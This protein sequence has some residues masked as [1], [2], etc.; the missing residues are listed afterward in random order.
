MNARF[1]KG[2]IFAAAL[3][4]GLLVLWGVQRAVQKPPPPTQ[5]SQIAAP[6]PASAPSDS[7]ALPAAQVIT[8]K[9]PTGCDLDPVAQANGSRDGQ[10]TLR[11]GLAHGSA[12]EPTAYVTV[13]RE[14]AADGR[15]RDAEIAL[16][17]A[18]QLA[19]EATPAP[20]TPLAD[21]QMKLAEH[22]AALGATDRAGESR[23]EFLRRAQV[24]FAA[25]EQSYEHVLGRQASKTRM[26]ARKLASLND[27]ASLMASTP[28]DTGS[29][30]AARERVAS[31]EELS[32]IDSDIRRLQAQASAL[33]RDPEG[34]RRRTEYA[35][36][37]QARCTDR[38][39]LQR[40]YQQR[41]AQLLQE[42]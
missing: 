42:F 35:D 22:Y 8:A 17:T 38:E 32:Q 5:A 31:D 40:W 39:C 3:A 6:K 1:R 27:P 37:R 2:L 4:A 15:L 20:S 7:S 28:P 24:L 12:P 30:G 36:S 9:H 18:C 16:I 41:R 14:A 10:F 19:G 25:S 23:S 29:M 11:T 13:A 33:T 21:I 26:A 34:F